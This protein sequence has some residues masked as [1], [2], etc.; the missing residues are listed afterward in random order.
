LAAV[1]V[2][3]LAAQ[4]PAHPGDLVDILTALTDLQSAVDAVRGDVALALDEVT[5]AGEAAAGIP[6]EKLGAA[7]AR[8]VGLACRT[9]PFHGRVILGTARILR[10]EMP[11]TRA[12][13]RSGRLTH[14]RAVILVKES[15]CLPVEAR[16][17]VDQELCANLKS[18][19]GVGT[20]KLTGLARAA[21]IRLDPA[22]VVERHRRAAATRH[23]SIR[24]LV[25]GMCRL[26]AT[27]PL[28]QG[29]GV[30]AALTH[31]ADTT[32]NPGADDLG[33]VGPDGQ[34]RPR[35]RGAIM[36]DTLVARILGTGIGS[37][38]G[39]A[40]AASNLPVTI[41]LIMSDETLL[42]AGHNPAVLLDHAGAG[43]GPIP[44][45]VARELVAGGLDA[46]AVWVQ[47]LFANPAG[48]L[49]AATS[50]RRFYADGLAGWL[51]VRDQGICRTPY[52]D[53]P[54]RQTDHVVPVARGGPTTL[55]NGAGL[56]VH[57]NQA[58][59][60]HAW[61]AQATPGGTSASRRHEVVTVTPTG[62]AY[63]ST[64]PK[65]PT[66]AQCPG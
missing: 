52:C 6:E 34:P 58:K 66:P 14:E 12:A 8:Q 46:G 24:P 16:R 27:L 53:A 50:T 51:R 61:R 22:S 39:T 10:E 35:G 21:A 30:Y 45:Q 63:V 33:P 5:R 55:T 25:D 57:C 37:P 19:N 40:P 43:Y 56:C 44:A 26:N 36:A 23:V 20:K 65:P 59:E 64:A 60:A 9:S 41:H 47:T 31:V 28:A 17:Q 3:L 62:H 38:T 49:I 15:A 29:V 7:V 1:R 32:W 48:D 13:L 42:G 18:L 2:R 11:H 54:I 4:A